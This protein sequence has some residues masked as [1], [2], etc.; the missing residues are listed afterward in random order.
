MEEQMAKEPV[1]PESTGPTL[2][3]PAP[4]NEM[5]GSRKLSLSVPVVAGSVFG[6]LVLAGLF[7]VV[8]R[9]PP[10]A[11]PEPSEESL[12][13][14]SNVSVSDFYLSVADNMVGSVILYLDGMVN[15][16]GDR[17]VRY[18]RVRLYFYDTLSQLILRVERDIVT[19]DGEP[20]APGETR[21][22]Q[23]RFD[24][25]PASW[26]LQPPQFQLVSLEI[27]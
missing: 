25:P 23:L 16:K 15:N 14:L 26:N 10:P 11:P 22:F 8:G 17:T 7:W 1:H 19:L 21:D 4:F 24:R 9:P 27:E 12:E 5:P 13:Y 18:L 2:G 20:L 3:S 6:A